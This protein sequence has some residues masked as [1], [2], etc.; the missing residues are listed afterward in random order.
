MFSSVHFQDNVCHIKQYGHE[1]DYDP[2]VEKYLPLSF[3]GVMWDKVARSPYFAYKVSFYTW[4][5]L[6]SLFDLSLHPT[7]LFVNIIV[8][9]F[10]GAS[11]DLQVFCS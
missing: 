9:R 8:S 4:Y 11:F 6:M 3:T 5:I 7:F 2:I 10:H 1:V